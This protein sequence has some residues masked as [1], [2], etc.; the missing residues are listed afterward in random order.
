MILPIDYLFKSNLKIEELGDTAGMSEWEIDSALMDNS[1]FLKDISD[2][3]VLETF[4]NS[5]MMEFEKLGFAVYTEDYIDSFLFFQS[6]AYIL[7]IAQLELEEHSFEFEDSEL[8]RGIEYYKKLQLNAININTWLEISALNADEEGREL[9]YA[10]ETIADIV[11]GHFGENLFTGKVKYNY[12]IVKMDEEII[13]R[14]CELLGRRYAGYTYDYIM[15]EYIKQ[16]FPSNKKL[17]FYMHY[18]R[19]NKTLDTTVEDRFVEMEE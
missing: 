18:N 14:Y 17:R 11:D 19:E 3:I 1:I 5:L 15:N 13:Y 4:I 12:R 7:N 9:F 10:N 8:I 16:N 2:S 6:P